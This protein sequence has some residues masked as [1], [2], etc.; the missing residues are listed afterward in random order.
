ML[1]LRIAPMV[2]ATHN[3]SAGQK[4]YLDNFAL[5]DITDAY[6]MFRDAM[7][8]ASDAQTVA[9]EAKAIAEAAVG[10]AEGGNTNFFNP[11][12]PSGSGSLTGDRW[13]QRDAANAIVGMWLWDGGNWV[14]QTL[15]N[16]VIGNLDAG[17]S[18]LATWT[19]SESVRAPSTPTG[20]FLACR[21][22]WSR[23]RVRQS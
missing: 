2:P 8:A 21:R 7:D 17:G 11:S 15:N 6:G 12:P 1:E 20:S 16:E 14:R 4:L 9:G 18:H 23:I 5:T 22:T 3:N 10:A 13:F 19:V